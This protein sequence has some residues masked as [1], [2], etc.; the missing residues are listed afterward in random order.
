MTL[1]QAELLQ[2]RLYAK[3]ILIIKW[4]QC[5]KIHKKRDE[6]VFDVPKLKLF[7]IEIK[8]VKIR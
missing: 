3:T 5:H 7:E 2:M 8:S 4:P 6:K 1:Q